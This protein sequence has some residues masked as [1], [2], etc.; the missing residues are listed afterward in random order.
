MALVTSTTQLFTTPYITVAEYKQ[1][2]TAVDIDDLVGGGSAALNDQELANVIARAS[3]WVD[4]YCGQVLAATTETET[5]RAR[6]S[7]DGMLRVHPRYWPIIEVVS[8]SYGSLPSNLSPVNLST[9]WI[10]QQAV[11]CPLAGMTSQFLGPI[12]FS[13]SYQPTAEQFVSMTY[14]NGY[15]NALLAANTSVSATSLTVNDATGFRAGMQFVI[16]DGTGTQLCTV[17]STYT[18]NSTTVPLTS[19]LTSAHTAG[20]SVSALPPAVKHATICA[21][22]MILKARGTSAIVMDRLTPTNI[23]NFSQASFNDM[24]QAKQ[25]LEPFRR[26]L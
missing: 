19:A 23:Q 3:S 1:A 5:F 22:N 6:I 25:L 24:E 8:V 14:V 7:R 21:T 18:L 9:V 20:V 16:Y 10:E 2:P 17:A 12:D 11:V 15:P 13:G 4:A 26:V